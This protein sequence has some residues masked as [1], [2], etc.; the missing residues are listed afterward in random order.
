[1]R[2]VVFLS[3]FFLI[4][5][6]C[7]KQK[8]AEPEG[9]DPHG[10]KTPNQKPETPPEMP[11]SDLDNHAEK[12]ARIIDQLSS[13]EYDAV[14]AEFDDQM[15]KLMDKPK[16]VAAWEQLISHTGPLKNRVSSKRDTKGQFQMISTLCEFEKSFLTI[17]L[18]FNR[19]G[20]V[21]G[22]F[23]APAEQ[24]GVASV[25]TY[26]QSD[27]FSEEHVS[28][29]EEPY[30]LPGLLTLPKGDERVP[31]VVLV[32]GSGPNDRDETIGPNKPFRDLAHGLSSG[33]IAVLR[34]DKRT[35]V[36]AG[37]V[38]QDEKNLTME[39]ET[40]ED[41]RRAVAFLRTQPRVHPEK[42]FV[43]GH[44]LGGFA[45][46]RIARDT[47]GLAGLILLAANARPLEELIRSQV[48]FLARQDGRITDEEQE[49]IDKIEKGI[50]LVKDP[51]LSPETPMDQLPLG[52][53]ASYWL[54][55]RNHDVVAT[56]LALDLPILILQGDRDYQVTAEEDFAIWREKTRGRKNFTLK[57]YK[58]LNHLFMTGEGIPGPAEY[59]KPGHVAAEVVVDI[60]GFIQKHQGGKQP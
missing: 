40:M 18:T 37:I 11:V 16:L 6:S 55:L 2:A 44:S 23:F 27:R 22:L 39:Q 5:A 42:I 26:V 12:A 35:R 53:P 28:F 49:A 41:A 9:K 3:S 4:L 52:M 60:I 50:A 46:P 14:L 25:P 33:G 15:A 30:L 48:A 59:M 58:N 8:P 57:L 1:M 34:Y 32:H 24:P 51:G 19:N 20:Q 21:A 29:G 56:A 38:M 54:H 36:H 17:K 43:L 47:P 45:G 10:E 13:K 31:A 7:G